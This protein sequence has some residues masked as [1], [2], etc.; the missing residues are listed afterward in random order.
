VVPKKL[1]HIL[2]ALPSYVL[3]S[4]NIYDFQTY[5]TVWIKRTFVVMLSLKIPPHL[6][7]VA[8]L[9]CEMSVS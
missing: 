5:F 4:S 7:C 9:L 8:T 2:Y 1:A 6:K 3:T